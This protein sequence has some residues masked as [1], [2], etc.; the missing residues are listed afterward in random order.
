MRRVN[1]EE[2]NYK[3]NSS[4]F[5]FPIYLEK[6]EVMY[7]ILSTPRS[8]SNLLTRAL[9]LTGVAGAPEEYLAP[10]YLQDF[11]RRWNFLP[12]SYVN[13]DAWKANKKA[14]LSFI[15]GYIELLMKYRTSQ[16]GVFGI[17]IHRSHVY[18][19]ELGALDFSK[20][21]EG[22]RFLF[23]RR[24]DKIRQAI[25]HVIARQTNA[26]IIDNEW[27]ANE[28]RKND[29]EYDFGE[30]YKN[31]QYLSELDQQWCYFLRKTNMD[32]ISI[33]YE[34]LIS[35]YEDE[36]RRILI[37]L[38]VDSID[39]IPAPNTT[40]QSNE[41]NEEWYDRVKNDAIRNKLDISSYQDF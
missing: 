26:W 31:I 37:F 4:D 35:D 7:A 17:K 2:F 16:N 28:P 15:E 40:R 34:N 33:V 32:H 21:F 29:P 13:F 20:H 1:L 10:R 39:P 11:D 41:L 27:L 30:I 19:L 18:E 5:D 25:S 22:F 3:T 23:M 8:G 9:W 12:L 6:P 24:K 36:I 38:D 14:H